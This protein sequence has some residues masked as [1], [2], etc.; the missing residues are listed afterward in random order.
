MYICIFI[1]IYTFFPFFC[2]VIFYYVTLFLETGSIFSHKTFYICFYIWYM[3]LVLLG[4]SPQKTF[5]AERL[6]LQPILCYFGS[7]FRDIPVIWGAVQSFLLKI[8]TDVFC[9]TPMATALKK[10]FYST[11]FY[12][13]LFWGNFFSRHFAHLSLLIIWWFSH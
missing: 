8:F 9:I 13:R 4:K 12:R 2:I 11:P 1:Y 10:L 6:L 5:A 7:H 3:F